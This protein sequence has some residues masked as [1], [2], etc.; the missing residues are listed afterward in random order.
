MTQSEVVVVT[1]SSGFLAHHV[2]KL[3]LTQDHQVAEIRCLDREEPSAQ[4][5]QLVQDQNKTLEF[6]AQQDHQAPQPKIVKWIQGDIRDINIVERTLCGADCVIHCAALVDI[7]TESERQDADE[8]ESVNVLGTEILLKAAIR[9][10]VAKFIHVSSF[11]V[12]TGYGTIYYATESTLPET[13]W[14]LFGPSARTKKFAEAK[15]REYSSNKLSKPSRCGF[16]SLNAV[17]VRFPCI[18]GEFD[19]TYISKILE[20]A[21]FFNGKLRRIDNTW[22][23]QQPIYAGNAAWSLIKA[24]H[25]M[26]RDHTISGEGK[27]LFLRSPSSSQPVSS[28]NN[29]F[30][31]ANSQNNHDHAWNDPQSFTLPTIPQW[32]ILTTF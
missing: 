25:R 18:Y 32:A 14:L 11:E 17:I 8:L 26:D 7:W 12:Y 24:K 27:L 1:G 4:T 6:P 5:K 28:I 22:I 23:V 10:G 21:K 9:L 19:K 2:I 20:M 13:D 15:V 29:K 3:L 30:S 31:L 16:D